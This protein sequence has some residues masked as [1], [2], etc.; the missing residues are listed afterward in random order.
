[1][2]LHEAELPFRSKNWAVARFSVTGTGAGGL[3][4]SSPRKI[5]NLEAPN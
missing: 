4:V 2:L 3:G 5:S 1:M